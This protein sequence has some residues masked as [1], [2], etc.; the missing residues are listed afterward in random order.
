MNII[1][2]IEKI[3]QN[4]QYRY[5]SE[6]KTARNLLANEIV[7]KIDKMNEEL[8]LIEVDKT[9]Y[10][11]LKAYRNME[12]LKEEISCI[13]SNIQY[14]FGY[15]VISANI[16]LIKLKSLLKD[17]SYKLFNETR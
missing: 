1:A 14:T 11:K 12:I 3:L 17:E 7:S 6:D 16:E 4:P 10:E 9:D 5:M 8:N 15:D 2:E 13:E